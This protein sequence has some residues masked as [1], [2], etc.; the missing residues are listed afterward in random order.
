MTRK[1]ILFWLA[2]LLWAGGIFGLSC[3]P[4]REHIPLFPN[5]DK[6]VHGGL[7]GM[8]SML[9]FF[10][11]LYERGFSVWKAALAALLV[12][13]LYGA[14]DEFH[15]WFTPNRSVDVFDWLADTVGGSTALLAAITHR[16]DR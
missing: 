6:V 2:P 12:T 8:L 14:L 7:F 4:F 9:L 16:R 13:S 3:L 11:F 15:Q 5:V 1:G 10:A